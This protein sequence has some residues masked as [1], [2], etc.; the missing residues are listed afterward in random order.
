M[1]VAVFVRV[2]VT[3]AGA[4]V[5]V[6]VEVRVTVEISRKVLQKDVA[7]LP[8]WRALMREEKTLQ[9]EIGGG[10]A[11]AIVA[12]RTKKAMRYIV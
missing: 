11:A 2:A 4:G 12:Y 5:D 6:T 9:V 10:T 7:I 8:Q 1:D 3:V